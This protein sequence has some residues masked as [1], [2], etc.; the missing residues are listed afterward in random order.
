MSYNFVITVPPGSRNLEVREV[1]RSSYFIA[2]T[3]LI[4]ERNSTFELPLINW[5]FG[6]RSSGKYKIDDIENVNAMTV[7]YFRESSDT[8]GLHVS[9]SLKIRE[10]LQMPINIYVLKGMFEL[11]S[12]LSWSYHR[13]VDDNSSSEVIRQY[14]W[15]FESWSPCSVTC[16]SGLKI[17][18]PVCIEVSNW[19]IGMSKKEVDPDFCLEDVEPKH[20]EETC[21]ERTCPPEWWI[22]PWQKCI[23]RDLIVSFTFTCKNSGTLTF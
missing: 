22:G 11:G 8:E 13:E 12:H 4:S 2:A 10:S 6:I 16:G 5:N 7:D 19:Q 9:Q 20:L 23:A 14:E 1:G 3:V 17:S 15:T 21:F 18:E